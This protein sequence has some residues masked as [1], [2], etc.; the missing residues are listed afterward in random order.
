MSLKPTLAFFAARSH[1]GIALQNQF[2]PLAEQLG[3]DVKLFACSTPLEYTQTCANYDAIVIDASVEEKGEHNYDIVTSYPLDHILVVSRTYLPLNFWGL[4]DGILDSHIKTTIYGT[5]FYPKTKSNQEILRWL[6]LQLR[7][8]LPSLPRPMEEKGDPFR[9]TVPMKPSLDLLDRRR[10]QSGQIFISYRSQD[11]EQVE[12]LK[13]Q[14]ERGQFHQGQTKVV[15]YFPPGILSD[16]VM[17]EQRRW[18]IL[19]MIDRFIGPATEIWIYETED[20]YNSWWTLGEL[21]T[22]AYR[23]NVGYRDQNP[24]ILKIFNPRT[25]KISDLPSDYLPKMT[26]EQRKRMARWYVNTDASQGLEMAIG[27]RKLSKVPILGWFPYFNDPVWSDEFWKNPIL[28]CG[29]C[30]QIGRNR[31]QFDLDKFLWTID[32]GFTRLT[33]IQMSNV[34]RTKQISC[35]VCN[36]LYRVE[37][38]PPHYLF[39]SNMLGVTPKLVFDEWKETFDLKPVDPNEANLLPF[40]VYRIVQSSG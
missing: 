25:N 8:L 32:P 16:E 19:S 34:V 1:D 39:I 26:E 36:T 20:Y 37:E 9:M 24:P 6:D 14:I 17:T 35:P 28:D 21:A 33:P 29:C 22:L 10:N 7:D 27:I 11:A 2:S 30:R 23:R 31:N 40:P 38:A 4:R 12:K 13:Q 15:R 3:F 5:P 18:Q